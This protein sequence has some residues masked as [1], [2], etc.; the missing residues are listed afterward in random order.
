VAFLIWGGSMVEQEHNIEDCHFKDK[1]E[2]L[3]ELTKENK[4][5]IDKLIT[6]DWYSN[7]DLF[8]MIQ[9]LQINISALNDS[10]K[11]YFENRKEDRELIEKLDGKY[12]DIEKE[13]SNIKKEKEVK[14]ETTTNWRE[15]IAWILAILLAIEKLGVF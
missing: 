10:F 2:Q 6:G 3:S 15:W 1:I 14:E 13:I 12:S 5:K 8:K 7:K 4:H 11:K 9:E